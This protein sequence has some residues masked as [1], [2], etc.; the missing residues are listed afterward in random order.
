MNSKLITH[1]EANGIVAVHD[2]RSDKDTFRRPG[3][4]G[5]VPLDDLETRIGGALKQAR[6]TCGLTHADVASMLGLHP[7]VYGRYERGES[8]LNLTRLIQLS[9]LLDFSP[10]DLVFAAAP[11]RFGST[12]EDAEQRQ[13]LVAIVETLPGD[14]VVALLSLVKAMSLSPTKPS[15]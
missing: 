5:V 4:E 1:M 10:F 2:P 9:E 12:Q 3:Y 14:A 13:R 7:Q 8:K 11:Y 15:L 6:E